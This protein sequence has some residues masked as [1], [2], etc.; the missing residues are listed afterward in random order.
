MCASA[1]QAGAKIDWSVE[2]AEDLWRVKPVSKV[3]I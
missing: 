3:K 2:Q 1:K